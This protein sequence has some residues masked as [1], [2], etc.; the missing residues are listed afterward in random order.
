[1]EEKNQLSDENKKLMAKLA[2]LN[3]NFKTKCMEAEKLEDRLKDLQQ[4]QQILTSSLI[5]VNKTYMN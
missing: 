1:M 2:E 4:Q 5:E 3:D